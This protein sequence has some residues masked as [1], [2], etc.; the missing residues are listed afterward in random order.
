MSIVLKKD[1][2]NNLVANYKFE[3]TSG[4]I[5][6]DSKGVYNGT[7]NG[8]TSV[9]GINGNARSFNGASDY[10]S[11]TNKIMPL[12]KK[13]IKIK[14]KTT[15][16]SVDVVYNIF[17]NSG[18]LS[19]N[20]GWS[21]FIANG[22][23]AFYLFK[24]SGT[25]NYIESTKNI[26][27]GQWHIV[28]LTWTGDLSSNGMKLYVDNMLNP[29]SQ[30][31]AS[32]TETLASTYNAVIGKQANSSAC[33]FNGQLDEFEVYNDVIEY[34]D[35][36]LYIVKQNNKYYGISTSNYDEITTHNF[37]PLILNGGTTPNKNDIETFGIEDL[38][39]FT[40]NMTKGSDTFKPIDKF[41]NTAELKMYK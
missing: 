18:N 15:S 11:F 38:S 3:E 40:N 29:D 17:D 22:K 33:F 20:K 24:G 32:Y 35:K 12:G 14:F 7:Y 41:D 34:Y 28:L 36:R 8:T 27:D 30:T 5:C 4:S 13:S 21:I 23:V 9:I 39:L 1:Y 26:N 37:T 6:I 31:T 10:V 2:S 25:Y 16:N 19:T